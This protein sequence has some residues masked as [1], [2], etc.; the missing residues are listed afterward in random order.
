MAGDW[1]G[2]GLHANISTEAMRQE[3]G[4]TVI[5][6]AIE[7]FAKKHDEHIEV[8]DLKGG[9]D[10]RRRLTGLHF[11]AR[12]DK[13]TS[14]VEDREASVRIPILVEQAGCGYF[15][16]RRPASNADPYVIADRIVQTM[17]LDDMEEI[18]N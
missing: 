18:Q 10:N 17:I 13:F 15:E 9:E 7:K 3:G 14:G 1:N 6:E 16:D 11:T 4:L 2:N 5:K 8:Y 12:I